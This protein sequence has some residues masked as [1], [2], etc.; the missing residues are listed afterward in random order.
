M[1]SIIWGVCLSQ[2][3]DWARVD[4]GIKQ[5]IPFKNVLDGSGNVVVIG[6]FNGLVTFNDKQGPISREGKGIVNGYIKKTDTNGNIIWLIDLADEG[7]R[8]FLKDIVVDSDDNLLVTGHFYDILRVQTINGFVTKNE[9]VDGSSFILKITKDGSILWLR[10]YAQ[11]SS[12]CT[13]NSIDIYNNGDILI[14]GFFKGIVEFKS[15]TFAHL[16][17]SFNRYSGL[18]IKLNPNGEYL[19]SKTFKGT[20][21]SLC[22][23]VRVDIEGDIVIAG[24]FSGVC[25]FDPN[26]DVEYY[27]G[28]EGAEGWNRYFIVKLNQ[29]GKFWWAY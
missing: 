29:N 15:S 2:D 22:I 8:V 13:F 19:W 3:L 1:A 10:T 27:L 4:A 24:L 28:G 6:R 11:R 26:K 16:D 14:G 17:T 25:D 9:N 18:V 5:V 12:Q 21:S 23:D 20:F 7:N